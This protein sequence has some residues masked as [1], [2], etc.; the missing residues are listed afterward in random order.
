VSRRATCPGQATAAASALLALAGL[1]AAAPP[2]A[3]AAPAHPGESLYRARCAACHEGGTYKAPDRLFLA[4]MGP[5]AILDSL[6]GVMAAQ[7]Q[8]LE[9]GERRALAEYLAGAPLGAARPPAA[10]ECRERDLDMSRPPAQLTWGIDYRN[11]RFQPAQS[12]GLTL[13]SARRLEL[14]WA[15]AYPGAIQARSQPTVAGGSVFVGSQSGRVY[16]LDAR[17]GC[18]RWTFRASAE[19]RTP[20]VISAWR[21]GDRS[22]RPRAYF[23][24]IL[25]RAYALDA[26][27]GELL[28]MRK[29]D[30][31]AGATITGAPVPVGDVV[32]VPVSSLEVAMAADPAYAC[33]TFRGSLVALDA[34]TGALRWKRYTIASEARPA[35]RTRAGTPILAPSGAPI[36]NSPTVDQRRRLLY[37][38]TGENYASPAGDTSDA[39]IAFRMDDGAIRWITQATRGDAW[40]VGCLSELAPD[41][42]NCPEENGPDF[43]FAAPPI[44]VALSDGSEVLVAGQKSGEVLALDPENGA[45]RWRRRVGRGGVQGGTHFGMAAE[46]TRVYVPINDMRYPEDTTRYRFSTPPRPGLYALDAASG[47]ELWARPADDVCP[48]A[49]R[50]C[51]PGISAAITAIPGGVIAGHLDGR[52]RIYAA[53]DGEVVWEFA[54]AR[55]FETV[56]GARARGGSMSGGGPAVAAGMLYVN[57]GYGIYEHMPGNV[58]LAF[59]PPDAR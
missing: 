26:R 21:A 16:A 37:A 32:Y 45:I 19:V 20:I 31:H 22:A 44:L 51:D 15:F 48:P 53:A 33:C 25:A 39:I 2:G 47:R 8:G 42:A 24:D 27:S 36:W 6:G 34:A 41:P 18:V 58:L 7:A 13:A 12:G 17:T 49:E 38:G 11:T 9:P 28:W 14:R 29:V 1:L 52:L 56:S 4:M 57:S 23:G 10:P 35:G 3:A 55:E 46:G 5:E 50:H 40:N 59:G 54:T 30:D 43:D